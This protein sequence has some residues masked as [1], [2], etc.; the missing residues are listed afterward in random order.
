MKKNL[1]EFPIAIYGAIENYNEVLSKA[2]CRIFYKGGN[3]NGTYIT[4]EF[5]DQLLK[6]LPYVPVKGIYDA[7]GGD[8]TDHG[9]DR[10]T[11]RIYGIVPENPNVAWEKHIDEDGV[12]R[13]YACADV[14]LFTGIYKEASEILSKSQSMEL[15]EPS[16]SYHFQVIDGKRWVVFDKA[17]FL[18]LQV[19][20]DDIE[21]C[22]EGA[23]FFSLQENIEYVIKKINECINGGQSEMPFYTFKLSDSAKAEKLFALLNPD[24]T[25]EGGYVMAYAIMDIYDEYVLTYNYELTQYERVYY[26]KNDESDEITLGDHVKVFVV[27]VTEDEYAVLQKLEE[28]NKGTYEVINENLVNAD[29]NADQVVEL[30]N[31]VATKDEEISEFNR[32]IEELNN[33]IVTLNTSIDE[34]TSKSAEATEE[35]TKLNGQIETLT[36]YKH[37]VET[38]QKESII[39][40]YADKLPE[41]VLSVYSA[42]LDNY[43]ATDLDKELAYELKKANV[44]IFDQHSPNFVP[45]DL[46]L[47]GIDAILSRYVK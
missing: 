25:E 30:T 1:K 46:P 42:N 44:N 10:D 4:D 37:A 21:P 20:G 14:L 8:Y 26:T 9:E 35:I 6:T 13:E 34:F 28:L 19:L 3:R 5:A 41:E 43:S 32:K 47:T 15:Y 16:I 29:T 31:T 2:R 33:Q 39:A 7:E 24:C 12:E 17:S 45:K 18:G 23:S 38:A 27:D 36:A 11:G 22:F 40:E